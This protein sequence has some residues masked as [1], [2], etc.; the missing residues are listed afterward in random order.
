[1]VSTMLKG[2]LTRTHVTNAMSGILTTFPFST[3]S[4][5]SSQGISLS[6]PG[7]AN[8]SD[9]QAFDSAS[10]G[11]ASIDHFQGIR[12]AVSGGGCTPV[13]PQ[14]PSGQFIEVK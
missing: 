9:E 10:T 4:S 1:M 8:E 5:Y 11:D 6:L 13:H 2:F 12:S 14:K 3:C 7:T